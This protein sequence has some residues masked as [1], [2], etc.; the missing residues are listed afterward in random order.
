MLGSIS[1]SQNIRANKANRDGRSYGL[2]ENCP[3][4]NW[5]RKIAAAPP[6]I[7]NMIGQYLRQVAAND[8]P[9]G[10]APEAMPIRLNN[11]SR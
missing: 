5:C 10:L 9:I 1:K 2:N 6:A 3:S 4:D 8:N 7:A 11:T